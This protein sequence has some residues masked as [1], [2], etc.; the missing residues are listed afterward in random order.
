MTDTLPPLPVE[1]YVDADGLWN[2]RHGP[3]TAEDMR[4]YALAAVE[5][6]KQSQQAL[7]DLVRTG[8]EIGGYDCIPPQPA[9]W[10]EIRK[11]APAWP[12]P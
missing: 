9:D 3:Y 7:D 11:G 12:R 6:Y 10:H 4:A 8:Q 2:E 1:N 5:A